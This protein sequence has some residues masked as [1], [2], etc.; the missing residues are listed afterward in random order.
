M[1]R[2]RLL[3]ILAPALLVGPGCGLTQKSRVDDCTRLAQSLRTENAQLKD[4][5]L[6]L[7]GENTDLTGRAVDDARRIGALEEANGRLESSVQDYIDE[8]EALVTAFREME[9]QARA[10][11]SARP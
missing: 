2:S 10:T 11:A 8:R 5:T 9:R 4:A 3:S 1:A 6:S 7:R